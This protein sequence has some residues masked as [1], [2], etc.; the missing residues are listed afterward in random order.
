MNRLDPFERT[1]GMDDNMKTV[2]RQTEEQLE[3]CNIMQ[4]QK[5]GRRVQSHQNTCGELQRQAY[6]KLGSSILLPKK[7]KQLYGIV[8]MS[9][10]HLAWITSMALLPSTAC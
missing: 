2:V 5:L 1:V 8:V 9:L 3:R 6:S 10:L 7:N 4:M